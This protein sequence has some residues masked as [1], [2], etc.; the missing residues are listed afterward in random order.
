[1][2]QTLTYKNLYT[3]KPLK[4]H[5]LDTT[6]AVTNARFRQTLVPSTQTSFRGRPIYSVGQPKQVKLTNAFIELVNLKLL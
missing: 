3:E 5:T 2:R 6:N 4:R 1:M